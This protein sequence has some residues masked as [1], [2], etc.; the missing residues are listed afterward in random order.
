M[1]WQHLRTITPDELRQ[2]ITVL[3]MKPAQAARFLGYSERTLRRFLRGERTVPVPDVLLLNC[4]ISH[5]LRPLV[6]K[7]VSGTY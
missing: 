5:R 1:S 6:P 2:A 3:G 7:K 4:M